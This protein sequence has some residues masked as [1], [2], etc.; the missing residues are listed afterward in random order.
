MNDCEPKIK[1]IKSEKKIHSQCNAT[2]AN[3]DYLAIVN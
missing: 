1:S 2:S 3:D